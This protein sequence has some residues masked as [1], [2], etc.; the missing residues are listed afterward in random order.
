MK[1]YSNLK[2]LFCILK[3]MWWQSWIFISHYL[4]SVTWSF[5]NQYNCAAT[6]H[7]L[8]VTFDQFNALLWN[9]SIIYLNKQHGLVDGYHFWN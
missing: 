1:Y 5:R 2:Q 3:D 4:L 8:T 7:V 6:V 9:K